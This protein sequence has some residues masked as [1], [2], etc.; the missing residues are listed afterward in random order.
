MEMLIDPLTGDYSGQRTT[1]LA[2][3]VYFRLITPLGSWWADIMLGSRL[4]ELQREKDV[5]RVNILAVQYCE[6]A[7]QP[8]MDDGRATKIQVSATRP[9]P[10]WL[11]LIIIVTTAADQTETFKHPVRVI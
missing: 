2:N 6:Q 11:L 9:K 5:P 7:L 1:T 8:L 4:H 10:G 3:A